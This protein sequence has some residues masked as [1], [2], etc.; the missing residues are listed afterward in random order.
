MS[1]KNNTVLYIGVTSNLKRRV[2]EHK[3]EIKPNSFTA[4]YNC[5]CLVYF[6]EYR[7]PGSAIKREK[8]LKKLKRS[9]KDILIKN[10]NPNM[11]DLYDTLF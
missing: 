2:C 7:E 11:S 4:R 9:E 3:E 5:F 1:N 6:E 10:A 8:R